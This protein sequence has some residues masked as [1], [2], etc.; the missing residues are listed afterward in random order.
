MGKIDIDQVAS[1]L[2]ALYYQAIELASEI[3]LL[4]NDV[5]E[6]VVKKPEPAVFQIPVMTAA[7][8]RQ[9]VIDALVNAAK[10]RIA[11]I[12]V[13]AKHEQK[14]KV[15][16]RVRY[17]DRDGNF[18]YGI[19]KL[20]TE[21]AWFFPGYIVDLE[22]RGEYMCLENELC[23]APEPHYYTG[24]VFAVRMQTSHSEFS[25]RRV[26]HIFE[27][28]D[29]RFVKNYFELGLVSV[30]IERFKSFAEFCAHFFSTEWAEVK[31][32]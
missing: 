25:E 12:P 23:L 26:G 2:N 4:E 20:V 10:I 27:I 5:K 31:E 29:G 8:H 7:H 22:K 15:G 32:G 16:D 24:K 21:G 19:V 1:R 9:D 6:C 13:P 3:N 28:K 11:N 17:Y 18:D 30:N 14:F